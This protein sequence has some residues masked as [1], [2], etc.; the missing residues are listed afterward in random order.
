MDRIAGL[1]AALGAENTLGYSGRITRVAGMI[2]EGVLPSARIGSVCRLE[3]PGAPPIMAQVVGLRD[4]RAIMM[5]LGPLSGL[6]ADTPI[7]MTSQQWSLDLGDGVLG[8]VLDG[9]GRP[10]DGRGPLKAVSPHI[11]DDAPIN[12]L[13]RRTIDTPLDLGVAAING[14]IT[15]GEGQRIAILAGAG[16]GKST[17]L[18]MMARHTRADVAVIALIGERGREV[19]EFVERD[20]ALFTGEQRTVV[21]AATSDQPAAMRIRGAVTATAIAEYFRDQG[22]RV[23][24]M[25]DSLT[26][27]VMAQREVG[28]SVGEPPATRGYPPSA[29]AVI[30]ALCERAGVTEKGSITGIYTTLVEADD[31]ND[32]VG[33]AVRATTDGHI[34]L[35]RELAEAGQFPAIDVTKSLSR[36]MRQVT[37]PEHQQAAQMFRTMLVDCASASDLLSLGAYRP[38]TNPSYDRALAMAPKTKDFLVQNAEEGVSMEAAIADLGRLEAMAAEPP[39]AGTE[40]R[41]PGA[42]AYARN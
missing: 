14:L 8:R 16:V 24:L 20:L 18:A 34:V 13:A 4:G 1:N 11:P 28:L 5:P 25:M 2:I 3:P 12:P 7:V 37:T 29:F 35:S 42:Q 32:P 6:S 36:V 40:R 23:L 22:K 38:G 19:Q 31:L 39:R 26:R 30:P 21:V 10:I 15:A 9:L 27:V 41:A 33:D 17:L